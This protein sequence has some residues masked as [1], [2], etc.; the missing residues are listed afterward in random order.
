MQ[1]Y[2]VSGEWERQRPD[3]RRIP[4]QDSSDD[5]VTGW[6]KLKGRTLS[7]Y[8]TLASGEPAVR[9]A[10][11]TLHRKVDFD[12]IGSGSWGTNPGEA[13]VVDLWGNG[14]AKLASLSVTNPTVY[15]QLFG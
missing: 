5:A 11:G 1:F 13:P 10:S 2:S 4:W 12:R 15:D 14:I 7:M 3:H 9:F 6:F 8:S